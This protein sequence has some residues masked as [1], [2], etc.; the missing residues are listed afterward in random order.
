MAPDNDNKQS[1]SFYHRHFRP[2]PLAAAVL[3]TLSPWAAAED[4][5]D[6]GFL[7]LAGEKNTVDLSVFAKEGGVAEGTYTVAVFVNNRSEGTETLEFRKNADG[8]IAPLLTPAQLEA[9]GVNVSGVPDMSVLP[10][11]KT[12]DNLGKL[13]PQASAKLDLSRLRLDISVPQI[14]MSPSYARYADPSLWEDGI[15]ALLTNYNLSAGR[16]STRSGGQTTHSD[17]LFATLRSGINAGPWR[18]R[19][20]V[21]H[22]YSGGSGHRQSSSNT[23]FSNTYL[24]R[25][26]RAL[27]SSLL[28]GESQ[29]GS[30]IF[31]SVP[32][33]GVKLSSDDQMLP[34][35]LRGFAPA[36]S[37]VANSN[38]RVTVRQN[39]NVVYETYVAPGP[40]YIN[41]IQQSGMSGD[42]DVTVTE[43]DGSERQ[44]VVPYS[45]LPVM[46][47]P[48]GWKYELTGG[49]YDG[50]L[51]QGSRSADFV[52]G[53]AVYGLPKNIT[54]YGG[55]LV[56]RDYQSVSAGSG[57]SLGYAGALSADITHSNARFEGDKTRTGKSYRVRYSKSLVSTGTSVDLTALRYTT[58]HYYS[59]SE[60][61][62]E[63]Y[64]RQDGV[65][66]WTLQ[67]RRSSFQTQISQNM[68]AFGT[69]HLRYNRDDYW[70][71]DKT[72]TGMSLG[73][74]NSIKGVGVGVNYNID[75][76]K[77]DNNQWPENRQVSLNVS[78]PFSVFGYHRDFQAMYATTSVTHDNHGKTS[79]YAGLSGNMLD[80]A[81]SYSVNQSWGN[82]GQAANSNA[83][84]GYQGSRG[85]V[86]AGYSYSDTTQSMNMNL[87]GGMLVHGDGITLSRSLGESVALVSAPDAGGV[88]V[89]GKSAVT[90][91]RGYAVVP[92]LTNYTRNSIGLDPTTL[93]D[94]VDLTQTNVNVYPTKG[95]VVKASFATRVGYKV[96]MTLKH[97]QGMV[98]FGAVASLADTKQGE[99]ISGI[100]G[101]FGQVYLAGLPEIGKL[102]VKWGSDTSQQCAAQFNLS[103]LVMSPDMAIQQ[104]T[105]SCVG[106]RSHALP[107]LP[108]QIQAVPV[109]P[110]AGNIAGGELSHAP[111]VDAV[112]KN[113][114]LQVPPQ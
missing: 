24:S 26:I 65:N 50:N 94:N 100:V 1:A 95:A 77:N 90:D 63:G 62:S 20:T 22:T 2:H 102:M 108:S 81:L 5:F 110:A 32:F 84:I 78:V 113:R 89:N 45:S 114:W 104:L 55:A 53:T 73:Y 16:T 40:F 99:D 86:S 48:G 13:I 41:D 36:V 106:G 71:S 38:A 61:N 47:R 43:A 35:Q 69:L 101:D 59:F 64:R 30:E 83:N 19:S 57:I 31:D 42:Y 74:S 56:A 97:G 8:V 70:G 58:E 103:K 112:K 54:L 91:S 33:K 17:N 18:L 34:S 88:G 76:I 107:P 105:V 68:D 27:R 21:T 12:V 10:A 60:F 72:L 23:R 49:R 87:S 80:G 7:G 28:I 29:T 82:Q 96:L 75:R 85:S 4:Y 39:G 79:N 66:P 67:R 37:G 15:P 11:D 6:P 111:A 3:L 14:A 52:L 92:Y 109:I 9:W 98:P 46:L 51:T 25:D 44:F 93:P